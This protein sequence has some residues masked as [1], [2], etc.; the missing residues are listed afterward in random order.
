MDRIVVL[1]IVWFFL[2]A[3]LVTTVFSYITLGITGIYRSQNATLL[4]SVLVFILS[5]VATTLLLV[6]Y[7]SHGSRPHIHDSSLFDR[8]QLCTTVLYLSSLWLLKIS[9]LISYF[10]EFTH[11]M[12]LKRAW[13]S[14]TGMTIIT[15]ACCVVNYP[16]SKSVFN[17]EGRNSFRYMFL[18]NKT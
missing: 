11:H 16:C 6:F 2:V 1:I 15:Y 18:S 10:S 13:Y 4:L 5:S 14:V 12:L 7:H 9:V 3:V 17:K 8:L